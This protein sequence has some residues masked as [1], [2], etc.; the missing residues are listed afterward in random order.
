MTVI[1]GAANII[2]MMNKEL[3]RK[4]ESYFKK[5]YLEHKDK[6]GY[7]ECVDRDGIVTEVLSE[8]EYFDGLKKIK[9]F[10]DLENFWDMIS[11]GYVMGLG[12]LLDIIEKEKIA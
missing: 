10:R 2:G 4:I 1:N 6:E 11:G 5:D 7:V 3:K 9:S 8:K 12:D